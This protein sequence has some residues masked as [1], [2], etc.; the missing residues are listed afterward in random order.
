[1][2]LKK[3]RPQQKSISKN[4]PAWHKLSELKYIKDVPAFDIFKQNKNIN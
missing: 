1:M 3:K 2:A 4:P